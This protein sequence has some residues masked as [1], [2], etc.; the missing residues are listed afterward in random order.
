M[1]GVVNFSPIEMMVYSGTK[2][3]P[4][5]SKTEAEETLVLTIGA[6]QTHSKV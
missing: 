5:A 6:V 2:N 3:I 4:W 1:S